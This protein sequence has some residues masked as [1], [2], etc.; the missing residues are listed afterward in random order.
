MRLVDIAKAM[1]M[2]D[3]TK[4]IFTQQMRR[5]ADLPVRREVV[6][7]TVRPK[8]RGGSLVLGSMTLRDD[9]TVGMIKVKPRHRRKKV[10]TGLFNYGAEKMGAK[11]SPYR[12]PLGEKFVPTTGHPVPPSFNEGNMWRNQFRGG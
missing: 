11:H 8:K 4:V 6:A 12:T 5:E 3:G 10:G 1:R 9:G 2:P 7:R